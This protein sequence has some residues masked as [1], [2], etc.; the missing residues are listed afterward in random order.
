MLQHLPTRT[1]GDRRH[2]ASPP[3]PPAA[4]STLA[5]AGCGIVG[6]GTGL[7]GR[8]RSTSTTPLAIPPLARS[9]VDADGTRVF[10]LDAQAGNH[11]VRAGRRRATPGASTAPTSAR[12]SSPTRGEHVRVDVDQLARRADHR[13][14]ARH[15]PAR[16]DGR[17]PAPDG[18][19][20]RHVV[21]RLGHRPA[22]G[23]ALVPPAPARRDREARRARP[24]RA[25][26]SC[27][28]THERSL[29]AAER[30]RRRRR[31]RDRAGHRLLGRRRARGR[32]TR[33]R[34]RP[35][36][37]AD[38]QRHARPVP[39]RRRRA[40]PAAAAQRLDGAHLRVHLER[41]PTGRAHRDRRRAARGAGPTR[42]GA[43]LARRTRRGARAGRRRASGSCCSRGR[44]PTSPDSSGRSPT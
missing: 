43:A 26:S 21:A 12:R 3:S 32:A 44:R 42:P 8:R 6:P 9:T 13:A 39:R 38:R 31:A 16:R 5:F 25:C 17:R 24:R 15:A 2:D 10:A 27:T 40:R 1:A 30:V 22:G 14:L 29:G 33:L 37:R 11:G 19:A 41:R 28:T 34:R 35:R 23:D 4:S 36:R 18:R 7:D 20:G